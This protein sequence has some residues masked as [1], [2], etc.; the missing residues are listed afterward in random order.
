MFDQATPRRSAPPNKALVR[1]AWFRIALVRI[2]PR[3][4]AL[5]K[6]VSVKFALAKFTF[7]SMTEFPKGRV[8]FPE[9][10]KPFVCYRSF[11]AINWNA[12]WGLVLTYEL[13]APE[14]S[15]PSLIGLTRGE[16]YSPRSCLSPFIPVILVKPRA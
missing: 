4:C 7:D 9:G 14:T 6:S 10:I 8:G 16:L 15:S 13:V 11:T 2:M 1:S 12:R 3:R 5:F